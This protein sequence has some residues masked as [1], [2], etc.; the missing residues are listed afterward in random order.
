MSNRVDHV[1]GESL[2]SDVVTVAAVQMVSGPNV[3]EN[4]QTA[5][6]LVASAVE[7]G[8]SIVALPEYFCLLSPQENAKLSHAEQQG[9]G[10]I[11]AC[12]AALARRH[13]IWLCAGTLPLQSPDPAR[14]HNTSFMYG[15]DGRQVARYDKIHLFR[16]TGDSEQFDEGRT[17]LAGDLPVS[18]DCSMSTTNA[19][20]L[21]GEFSLRVGLSVCYDLRFP[22]LYRM[23]GAVDL[24]LVPSA[25]TYTTGRAHWE[26]LLKA[27]A[28]ENQCYVLAPAQGGIH[29]HGRHTWG[30]SMLI[31]PWGEIIAE[32][33]QGPGVIVGQLSLS[34]LR[35][36]RQSLP[37]LENRLL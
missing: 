32:Q 21:P 25:F 8:A 31:D 6:E 15:P 14:V 10:P 33:A 3:M 28:I 24:I 17:I 36:V 23:M 2:A 22:E 1:H 37:A 4:L 30:H 19:P 26:V 12:M 7:K 9:V 16:Y 11:Q 13:G 18:V 34:T 20:G 27:R 35:R 5:S 29:P